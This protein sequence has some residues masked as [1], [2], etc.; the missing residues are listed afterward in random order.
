MTVLEMVRLQLEAGGFDGLWSPDAE[1]ACKK[2][3]LAPCGEIGGDCQA[4]YLAPC[5][6]TCGEHDWHIA[7]AKTLPVPEGANDETAK[8]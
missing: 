1:C 8:L 7:K 6:E 3:D 4:G 5:P 2:D